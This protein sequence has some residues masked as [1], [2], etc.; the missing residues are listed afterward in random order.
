V[1]SG[2]SKAKPAIASS[3]CVTALPNMIEND[4][5][6][7]NTPKCSNKLK[8]DEFPENEPFPYAPCASVPSS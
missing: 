3:S 4:S 7:E 5:D 1:S 8:K 2:S 6:S